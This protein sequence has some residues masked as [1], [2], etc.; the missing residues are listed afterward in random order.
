MAE[1]IQE[2]KAIFYAPKSFILLIIA[3]LVLWTSLADA[4]SS[5]LDDSSQPLES[6]G[7]TENP[8]DKYPRVNHSL[9]RDVS[10]SSSQNG[11]DFTI[12]PIPLFQKESA[13]N[14]QL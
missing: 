7:F 6:C 9:P 13:L 10:I 12:S 5:F 4:Q 1:K 11:T 3:V 8:G 2:R 14:L